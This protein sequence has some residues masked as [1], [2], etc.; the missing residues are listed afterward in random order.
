MNKIVIVDASVLLTA[1]I[2]DN[3]KVDGLL[4]TILHDKTR[5]ASILSFTTMEFANGVRFST[6][7]IPLAKQ[8]LERFTALAL[9]VIPIVPKDVHAIIELSYR[10]NTTVYDTAYHYTAIMHDGIFITC[11]K[12]YFKKASRLGHIEL[13]R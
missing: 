10:L 7:D 13:W 12:G 1:I 9:P 4:R 8:A 11:D 6:R 3:R 2:G 5:S